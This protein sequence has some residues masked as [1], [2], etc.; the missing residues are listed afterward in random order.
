MKNLKVTTAI[1]A[2]A[3]LSLTAMSCKDTKKEAA[4]DAMHSE[5]NHEN[6]VEHNNMASKTYACPMKCEGDKT[7]DDPGQCPKC[8]M[9]LKAIENHDNHHAN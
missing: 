2:M 7:Y 4:N 6:S 8:G 3:F 9:D 1:L 5:M